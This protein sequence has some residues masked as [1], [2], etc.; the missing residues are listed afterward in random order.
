MK[1]VGTSNRTFFIL[2]CV[3]PYFRL[4]QKIFLFSDVM[5]YQWIL[6][7]QDP[8]SIVARQF[9]KKVMP[10]SILKPSLTEVSSISTV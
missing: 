8:A 3:K 10:H 9:V 7:I 1:D 2:Q 5:A 6:I 4:T